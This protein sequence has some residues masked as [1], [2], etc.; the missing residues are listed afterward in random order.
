MHQ[1]INVDAKIRKNNLEGLVPKRFVVRAESAPDAEKLVADRAARGTRL[2]DEYGGEV[3]GE[4]IDQSTISAAG[5][6]VLETAEGAT[7]RF[8]ID[9]DPIPSRTS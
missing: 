3:S 4:A 8:T 2:I 6:A 9:G 7:P 1:L 5:S